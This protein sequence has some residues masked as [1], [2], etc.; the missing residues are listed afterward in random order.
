[1][2]GTRTSAGLTPEEC[3]GSYS[4]ER[5]IDEIAKA[6]VG[7]MSARIGRRRRGK[8]RG[9]SDAELE[10]DYAIRKAIRGVFGTAYPD[11]P[12]PPGDG[13]LFAD[14]PEQCPTCTSP[15]VLVQVSG[16]VRAQFVYCGVCDRVLTDWQP[17]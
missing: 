14:S 3:H 12:R 8:P 2:L 1:L 17:V 4:L 6:P 5:G 16:D 11:A 9:W 15:T 13:W 10:A 7:L